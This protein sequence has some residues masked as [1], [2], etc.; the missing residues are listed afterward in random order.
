MSAKIKN[1]LY[2]VKE[3][4]VEKASGL[5]DLLIKKFNLAPVF[6]I[7]MNIL[8]MLLDNV[9]TYQGVKMINEY[10]DFLN[11]KFQLFKNFSI[12]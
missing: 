4:H 11:K 10:L 2:V 9:Q 6:E 7:L 8:K 5:F 3:D 1:P 12:I